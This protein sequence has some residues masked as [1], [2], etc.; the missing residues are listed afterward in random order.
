MRVP[1]FSL[2]VGT[3]REATPNWR[4]GHQMSAESKLQKWIL[5]VLV[6]VI[7]LA[8][9]LFKTAQGLPAVSQGIDLVGG[10]DLLLQA[11]VP[12]EGV[13]VTP[14]MMLGA[15]NIVRNRLDPDGV[16]EIV[17]QLMGND[18]IVVQI[19]NEDDPENVRKMIGETAVLRFIDVG[20]D[21]IRAESKIVFIDPETGKSA[22]IFPWEAPPETTVMVEHILYGP[23]D[24]TGFSTLMEEPMPVEEPV[25]ILDETG[26]TEIEAEEP[27]T[28]MP[29][30]VVVLG[31]TDEAKNM[32]PSHSAMHYGE[33]FALVIDNTVQTYIKIESSQT[34]SIK[35]DELLN[36]PG[37][38]E[39]IWNE[40]LRRMK[41]VAMMYEPDIGT[42]IEIWDP[43]GQYVDDIGTGMFE[44]RVAL[45]E[46]S[47]ILT[48]EDFADA[49]VGFN[50]MNQ[51]QIEFTFER[52]GKNIF[53]AHTARNVDKFLAIALDDEI[54][55]C[56]R[57]QEPILN[58]RGVI[59]GDFS[60]Q[61]AMDLV[62]QLDSGRLPVPLKIVENRTVGPSLGAKSIEDSK[63]AAI[64]GAVLVLLFMGIY[65]R[66]PG[67][68]A[69]TALIFYGVV[70]FGAL[71][72]LN[73]TL[74]LP[75]IAGFILS[76]GMAV[77]ANVIIFERLKEELKTGKTFRSAVDAAFKRAFLAI[78]D[79]NVT[80]LITA[81]VLYNL[82]TGPIRGFAVTLSLGILV[83][84]FSALVL[85]RLLLE[86]VLGNKALQKYEFF[87]IKEADV[88]IISKGGGSQ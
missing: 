59:T 11:Q 1:F 73:A 4:F 69:A 28:F 23:T 5:V 61:E 24:M 35:F 88:A 47:I 54:I 36:H 33:Y 39:E 66:L 85:T 72:I 87:G 46:T 80:T 52:D 9:P 79:A 49:D 68:A 74:T 84:M 83:S 30:Q 51:P 63:R 48:G 42:P 3:F 81:L 70:F 65:Y 67:I 40:N 78:F 43:A 60:R 12:E 64:L 31:L 13:T 57:I 55:S 50:Q 10:V 71:S 37:F 56:P 25:E 8:V 58:G 18:R 16:R 19:P 7:S 82:G 38:N 62:I 76:L 20:N 34:G 32:L 27:V 14:D 26:E 53:A 21:P 2:R 41:I 15:I 29:E 75:G 6:L 44:G 86:G 45:P 77:D 22:G 17:I